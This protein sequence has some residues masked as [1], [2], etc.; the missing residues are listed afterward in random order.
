MLGLLLEPVHRRGVFRQLRRQ[1]LGERD[2]LAATG[3]ERGLGVGETAGG[4]GRGAMDRLEKQTEQAA[5]A[6]RKFQA[7]SASTGRDFGSLLSSIN[8]LRGGLATL[9]AALGIGQLVRFGR[10]LVDLSA[11]AI[12]VKTKFDAAIPGLKAFTGSTELAEEV[13]DRLAGTADRLKTPLSGLINPFLGISSGGREAG[14]AIAEINDLFEQSLTSARAFG[15]GAGD[16]QRLLTGISQVAGKGVAS[17]E[18]FR[19]QIGEAIPNAIPALAKG[20]GVTVPEAIAKISSGSLDSATALRALTDG[21]RE[22]NGEAAEGQLATLAGDLGAFERAAER[23]RKE[24]GDGLEPGLRTL[25][26]AVTNLIDQNPDLIRQL[27]EIGSAGLEG[28]GRLVETLEEARQGYKV[29]GIEAL[30]TAERLQTNIPEGAGLQGLADAFQRVGNVLADVRGQALEEFKAI[31]VGARAAAFAAGGA[32]SE[33][34]SVGASAAEEAADRIKF[35]AGQSAEEILE[36]FR[37]SFKKQA[38]AAGIAGDDIEAAQ[39]TIADRVGEIAERSA[40]FRAALEEQLAQE[41]ERIGGARAEVE[42]QIS[43]AIFN[44]DRDAIARRELL[45]GELVEETRRAGEER[46]AAEAKAQEEIAALL[47]G[48]FVKAAE[49]S[50]KR[51]AQDADAATKLEQIERELQEKLDKL[52]EEAA[53]K[54]LKPKADR[55]AITRE[56]LEKI[57]EAERD[58]AEKIRSEQERVAEEAE[59]AAQ[60]R[61]KAEEKVQEALAKTVEK[62]QEIVD[63]LKEAAEGA[64]G[65]EDGG[66]FGK[67]RDQIAEAREELGA[68]IVDLETIN[69]GSLIGDAGEKLASDFQRLDDILG[70][71]ADQLDAWFSSAESAGEAAEETGGKLRDELVE[72]LKSAAD[73]AEGLQG[74]VQDTVEDILRRYTDLADGGQ[75]TR[76]DIAGLAAE[77]SS[78]FEGAGVAVGDDI[79]EIRQQLDS[80]GETQDAAAEKAKDAGQAQEDAAQGVA[81]E[82]DEATR[83]LKTVEEGLDGVGEAAEEGAIKLERAA[84][85]TITF[86]QEME[87]VG[88]A[89]EEAKE[90]LDQ[91]AEGAEGAAE[92][93]EAV[94]KAAEGLKGEIVGEE[95]PGKLRDLGAAAGEALPLI[96]PLAEPVTAIATAAGSLAEA[97]PI[98]AE[99]LPAITEA[100]AAILEVLAESPVDFEAL[101]EQI[102][103]LAEPLTSIS[104]AL[105]LISEALVGLPEPVA[106]LQLALDPLLT[107]ATAAA[108]AD[109]FG[110]I[111]SGLAAIGA[112]LPDI[113]EPLGK[114]REALE[115]VAA[116]REEIAGALKDT[117]AGLRDVGSEETLEALG[118][119]AELLEELVDLI[120][121]IAGK[122]EEWKGT[123]DQ[124]VED[125]PKL[126]QAIEA[127]Q[128]EL[129]GRLIPALASTNRETTSLRDQVI[130]L[131]SA[132]DDLRDTVVD[133]SA[134][135]VEAM[136]SFRE[137]VSATNQELERMVQLLNEAAA[138]AA[139]VQLPR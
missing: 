35:A 125:M 104:T 36:D 81:V 8:S 6:F 14:L 74:S 66:G 39:K 86:T 113:P 51:I 1:A 65:S 109:V 32:I 88:E 12:E 99:Q 103:G 129:N 98:L 102:A 70:T 130:A 127:L 90:G 57:V 117:A 72:A 77:I 83:T 31:E 85:G 94:A 92:P 82:W 16:V 20:L 47:D 17:M 131:A 78:A 13:A 60:R 134:V 25:L 101:A 50:E 10:A 126:I 44:I 75:V 124:I 100:T 2:E 84:D 33:G 63:K 18:E 116:K 46:I 139:K 114:I 121:D 89:A 53:E 108:E 30:E 7:A 49:V 21:F 23:A 76:E 62:F 41:H 118:E 138:A 4:G 45:L 107:S 48:V 27:G 71:G 79:A 61:I 26:K 54:L 105:P 19:Q 73:A 97:L 34:F 128:D 37:E 11:R 40:K 135:M 29:L 115:S 28:L 95:E 80:L 69:S 64:E 5:G 67:V 133:N 111:A 15:K 112:A 132:F 136:A 91:V 122:T 9:V 96:E 59:K 58:A 123:L 52:R 87:K 137:E 22:L 24:L 93:L 43:R 110:T 106:A 119:L 38:E 120:G 55:E 68:F 56:L 3:G 42:E